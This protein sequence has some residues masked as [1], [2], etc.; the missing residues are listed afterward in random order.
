[1]FLGFVQNFKTKMATCTMAKR[2]QL[3]NLALMEKHLHVNV[4]VLL[5]ILR[6]NS[7]KPLN[8]LIGNFD[9]KW[10]HSHQIAKL[11]EGFDYLN[12]SLPQPSERVQQNPCQ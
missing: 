8:R 12:V 2:M 10:K 6:G 4:K 1:M 7:A 5:P 9:S 3:V 11:L